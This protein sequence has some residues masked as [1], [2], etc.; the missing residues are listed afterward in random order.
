MED[1]LVL[2]FTRASRHPDDPEIP[3]RPTGE[4]MTKQQLHFVIKMMCSEMAEMALSV[5][6][7]DPLLA[8]AFV[9]DACLSMEKP[10]PYDPKKFTDPLFR[11]MQQIDGAVDLEIYLKN[12]CGKMGWRLYDY[13]VLVH[14][15][16]MNKRWPIDGKFH[17]NEEH[18]V[19]KPPG[20]IPPDDE[21][22]HLL[23]FTS[24]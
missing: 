6:D 10:K 19:I 11:T 1:D 24:K 8:K 4:P 2:E 20:F 22:Y 9:M 17:H 12:A 16:N 15:S 23:K 3:T 7:N 21:M 5:V 18:K 14:K 13:L